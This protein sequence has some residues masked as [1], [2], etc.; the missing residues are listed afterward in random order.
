MGGGVFPK[1]SRRIERAEY[2]KRS[3]ELSGILKKK[4]WEA[5]VIPSYRN[6][7]DFG[8][9]DIL[10]RG[11][12]I[13]LD[14]VLQFSGYEDHRRNGDCLSFLE[15]GVQVDLISVA[16]GEMDTTLAYFSWNDLGNLMGRIARTMGFR[17]GHRGLFGGVRD[18]HGNVLDNACL[19]RDPKTIFAFLGYNYD[20]WIEGFDDLV[21]IFQF[22]CSSDFFSKDCF[23]VR[24]LNHQSR[25]RNRKRKVYSAFLEWIAEKPMPEFDFSLVP[26]GF[27]RTRALAFFGDGW[28]SDESRSLAAATK[29]EVRRGKFN[30]TV[31]AE[32]TGLSGVELGE[33]ISAFRTRLGSMFETWV[34]T[35][36]PS[37]VKR[38]F[39]EAIAERADRGRTLGEVAADKAIRDLA[40]RGILGSRALSLDQVS[41]CGQN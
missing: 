25:V 32:G 33:V 23:L 38:V 22:A 2:E 1:K 7:Q 24:N 10:V 5:V 41:E 39:Q 16:D 37:D 13:L 20:R 26:L 35:S 34:D 27:W 28:V 29:A 31:V 9:I 19:S 30:G 8:D 40:R 17:Y 3:S 14:E 4:G 11:D 12:G 36:E 6:K 15:E 18:K 21:D